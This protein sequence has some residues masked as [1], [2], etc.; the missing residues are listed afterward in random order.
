[1]KVGAAR[2][3]GVKVVRGAVFRVKNPVFG[4]KLEGP[5]DPFIVPE[6]VFPKM[7][8]K[9]CFLHA[10]VWKTCISGEKHRERLGVKTP[11]FPK[12]RFRAPIRGTT[13]RTPA[14]GDGFPVKSDPHFQHH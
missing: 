3:E 13:G 1:M 6:A 5:R 8:E 11:F 4:V 2:R 12:I 10:K 9:G 7:G 14:L